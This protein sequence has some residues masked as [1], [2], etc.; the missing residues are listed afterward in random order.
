M[1]K[2][3]KNLDKINN[4]DKAEVVLGILISKTK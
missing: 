1:I 3:E 2:L 4:K